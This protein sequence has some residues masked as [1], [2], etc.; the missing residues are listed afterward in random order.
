MKKIFQLALVL[1]IL[2]G[3]SRPVFA[4]TEQQLID[5]VSKEYTIDGK[6]VRIR[7]IYIN[8][9]KQYLS[10]KELSATAADKIIADF[11][12]AVSI[13]QKGKKTDPTELA[14]A[15]RERLL[16]LGKDAA[17]QLNINVTYANGKLLLVDATNGKELPSV[18]VKNAL[19]INGKTS[20][21]LAKTGNDYT[22]YI[23]VSGLALVGIVMA[24]YRKLKGNA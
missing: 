2:L 23:A 19:V 15:D 12:E 18:D 7:D 13:M 21:T 20:G 8:Q 14:K 4:A 9:L 6:S 22:A 11:D 3:F 16:E 10:D 5:Y 1:T 24:G 17:R